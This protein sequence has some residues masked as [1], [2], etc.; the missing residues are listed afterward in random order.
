MLPS[1][2]VLPSK[3]VRRHGHWLAGAGTRL[4]GPGGGDLPGCVAEGQAETLGA[5]EKATSYSENRGVLLGFFSFW[6]PLL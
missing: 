6:A 3:Q 1:T 2:M 5:W 4:G